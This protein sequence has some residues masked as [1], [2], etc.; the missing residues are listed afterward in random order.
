MSGELK[1]KTLM[2]TASLLITAVT[3][4]FAV[5]AGARISMVAPGSILVQAVPVG[6]ST[7]QQMLLLLWAEFSSH[8]KTQTAT[9]GD[10]HA[11]A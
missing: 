3:T 8:P 10:S 7:M 11:N 6:V 4:A 1:H 5:Y 2:I 9:A